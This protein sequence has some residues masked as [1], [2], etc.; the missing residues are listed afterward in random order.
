MSTFHRFLQ[1]K[2]QMYN[3]LTLLVLS[4]TSIVEKSDSPLHPPPETQ[5]QEVVTLFNEYAKGDRMTA[6]EFAEFLKDQGV[7][8]FALFRFCLSSPGSCPLVKCT[9]VVSSNLTQNLCGTRRPYARVSPFPSVSQPTHHK[10]H[11]LAR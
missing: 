5:R 9:L 3:T 4:L 1:I 11:P 6:D 7:C 2:R 10:P 8:P